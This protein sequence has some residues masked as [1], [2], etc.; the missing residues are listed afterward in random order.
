MAP[1]SDSNTH[2]NL[3]KFFNEHGFAD[4]KWIQ[5]EALVIA[6]W[7]R[8][9]C[10]FGCRHYG[11]NASCPP[12]VPSV[13]ECERFFGEYS[14]IAIFHFE[15]KMDNPDDRHAWSK[16][17]NSQLLKLERDVFLSGYHKAFLL[18]MDSCSLCAQCT[19]ERNDCKQPKLS[20][21][22]P[23]GMGMD[24][25]TTVRNAGYFIQ[26]CPDYSATMNRYAFLLVG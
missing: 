14:D 12:N 6:Q 26:V 5:P 4:F 16:E 22:T 21:P 8:M 24:V 25:Y 2:E 15:K 10:M 23:E 13:A 17:V 9:K 19:E 11:G 18:F 3:A 20:R 1:N 7:V